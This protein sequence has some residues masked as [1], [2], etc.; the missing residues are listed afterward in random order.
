MEANFK[1]ILSLSPKGDV[2]TRLYEARKDIIQASA[3]TKRRLE[4]LSFVRE[5]VPLNDSN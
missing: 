1:S 2:D 3:R 4:A 5:F